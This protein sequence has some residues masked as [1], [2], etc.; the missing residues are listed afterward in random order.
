MKVIVK[1]M[2]IFGIVILIA[3]SL[4]SCT[5][6]SQIKD[7]AAG[8]LVFSHEE[9]LQYATRFTLTRYHNGY[10]VFRIPGIDPEKSYLIVPQGQPVPEKLSEN[11]VVLQQPID[12]ICFSSGSLASLA[13]A[14]GAVE[15]IATVG[16]KKDNWILDPIVEGM[17]NGEI[18]Y[19]GSYKT[20]DFE[21]MLKQG[22][23]LEIDSSMLVNYPDIIDKYEE[24]GIPCLIED[25]S[26]ES[27]PLGRMEW[28]KLLGAI[29]GKDEAA[30]KY[31]SEQA[32]RVE[33]LEKTADTQKTA[34]LF[35]I[36]EKAVYVRNAGDYVPKMLDLAGGKN[37]CA[38]LNPKQ[39]GNQ[40]MD[41]EEFYIRCKD[42]DYLF[43]VVMSCPYTT[44]EELIA[45]NELFAEFKAV[46]NGCVFTS[47]RGFAQCSADMAD[48]ILEMNSLLCD[49][50][51]TETENFIKIK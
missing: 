44:I 39:G 18:L 38:D 4:L 43:W 20:P 42:A 14:L 24:L 45:Y 19:S 1:R 35:Y 15:C 11:T 16:I 27:H 22:I 5:P 17:E 48:V 33:A 29:L 25:S 41:F 8:T 34:A 50:A 13:E 32:A 9:E 6:K 7:P 10:S 49:P 26:K 3:L 28:I 30:K 37:I 21:M 51:I 23:Q 36:G 31:F 12:R 47:R 40:K 46:K 2:F